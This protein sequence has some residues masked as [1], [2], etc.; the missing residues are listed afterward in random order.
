MLNVEENAFEDLSN[1]GEP[2]LEK[3]AFPHHDCWAVRRGKLH[4]VSKKDA[5]MRCG[6]MAGF[7]GPFYLCVPLINQGQ[8]IGL[9]QI[10][11]NDESG[12]SGD[13]FLSMPPEPPDE[14]LVVTFADHLALSLSN[15]RLREKLHRLAIRD[16][17]T[18]LYNRRYMEESLERE[19]HRAKRKG[20]ALGV[21]MVDIDHFKQF[22]DRHGH[23]AGDL[24]LKAL[25]DFLRS[26]VRAD[27]IACRYG[28]EEFTLI[29]PEITL[30]PA[31]GRA[32]VIRKGASQ[33]KVSCRGREL[34]PVTLSVGVA[35]Y[36][37]DG[38]SWE[39]VLRRADQAL[40]RA[41]DAGRNTVVC[42]RLKSPPENKKP[43]P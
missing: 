14:K 16:P 19:I 2:E 13:D 21:M 41:K 37:D 10:Q 24:L 29:L 25:G 33:L 22:N 18:G 5:T 42:A 38:Q 11:N 15:L 7:D 35:L 30:E 1:W 4:Q 32:E 20:V 31:L 27:D 12:A 34:E 6:H 28:G 26:R 3:N 23:E 9:L 43:H 36:P 40:Y 8:T 17:L 39:E